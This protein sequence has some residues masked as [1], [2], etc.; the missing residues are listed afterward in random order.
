M[1]SRNS[2]LSLFVACL[3]FFPFFLMAHESKTFEFTF[4]ANNNGWV[5]EFSNYWVGRENDCEL[6]W[7]WAS[8]PTTIP[9]TVDGMTNDHALKQGLYL[10][11]MNRPDDL[12]MFIKR[13][14][15]GLTP[16][17]IYSLRYSVVIESNVDSGTDAGIGGMPGKSVVFKVGASSEEPQK[18]ARNDYYF[19]NI[20]KGN[21]ANDGINAVIIGNI[22]NPAVSHNARVFLPLEL[23]Q[24]KPLYAKTD[25]EGKLWLFLGTDSGFEGRTMYYIAKINVTVTQVE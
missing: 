25:S 10:A 24:K 19:L 23:T 15:T 7:G 8:L 9:P 4:S 18:I 1:R 11:G 6:S 22:I 21:H 5:G 17:T 12:F 14:I 20:D 13:Q 2:R 16:N 3:V